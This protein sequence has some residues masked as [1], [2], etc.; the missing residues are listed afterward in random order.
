MNNRK[1]DL[2]IRSTNSERNLPTFAKDDELFKKC[3]Q[4]LAKCL[5]MFEK[6][7]YQILVLNISQYVTS[8]NVGENRPN[9]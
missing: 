8:S 2:T 1:R 7:E 3:W 9:F 5:T 6:S 4:M